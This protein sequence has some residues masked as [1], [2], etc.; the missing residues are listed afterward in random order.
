[1]GNIQKS[2][3][4]SVKSIF[5]L[6]NIPFHLWVP[7]ATINF[8]GNAEFWLQ[9]YEASHTINSWVELCIAVDTKFG[10]DIYHHVMRDLLNLKQVGTVEDY[11][12]KFEHIVRNRMP[13]SLRGGGGELGNL[14]P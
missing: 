7:F 8:K 11:L 1:M 14:K 3:G 2:G 6:Y 12:E 9:S 4:R 5:S 10:K 13:V